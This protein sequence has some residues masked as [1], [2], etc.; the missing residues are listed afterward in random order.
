MDTTASDQFLN[1]V[2]ALD[3]LNVSICLARVHEPVREFMSKDGIIEALGENKIFGRVKDAVDAFE[4]RT[5]AKD[6]D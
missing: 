5:R 2:D 6:A 3:K 1:L 4:G